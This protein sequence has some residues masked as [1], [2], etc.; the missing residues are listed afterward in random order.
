V[1][2]RRAHNGTELNITG[3]KN[4]KQELAKIEKQLAAKT[5]LLSK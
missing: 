3:S 2:K 1:A 4:E 5:K